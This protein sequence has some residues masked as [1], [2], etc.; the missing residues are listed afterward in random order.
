MRLKYIFLFIF[1][2]FLVTGFNS[3]TKSYNSSSGGYTNTPSVSTVK[4]QVK[5]DSHFGSVITDGS[6]KTLYFFAL[7]ANGSSACTGGCLSVW[8][9]FY[10]SSLT[11]GTGLDAADFST[12]TRSDGTNQTSY[13]GW[14]LYYYQPDVNAGDIHGDGVGKVWFVAKPD[15]TI[16]LANNQLVGL[17]GIKYDST[18][19]PGSGSTQYLTTDHGLT[20]YSFTL[21]IADS[22]KFTKSDFSNDSFFPIFQVS[23]IQSVPSILDKTSFSTIS[24]FGKTQLTFKGWPMYEFGADSL[25]RGNTHGISIPTPG[26]WP[27][28]NAFSPS[29]P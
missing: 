16:M 1:F 28:R 21:D 27:V 2:I 3:C 13:K 8:P 11:L 22:N 26:F 18:Y 10:V 7:D 12:I 23:G 24:V 15:Y 29:A 5:T 25:V 20:L 14:P 9:V 6:G 19:T 4:V 17:N